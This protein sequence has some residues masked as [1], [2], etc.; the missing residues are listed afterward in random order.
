MTFPCSSGFSNLGQMP[1]SLV[2]RTWESNS[3]LDAPAKYRRACH[4]DAFVPDELARLAI[5]LTGEIAGVLS[6]ADSFVRRLN[7]DEDIALAPLAHLLLRTESIASS[8]IEGLQVGA[9]QLARAEVEGAGNAVSTTAAELIDNIAAMELAIEQA[10]SVRSF[11]RDDIIAIHERLM[12][13][14]PNARVAGV[15]R[16]EQNWIGGNDYNPCAADFVPPPPEAI[17]GLLDDLCTAVNDDLL[18]PL[19]Q[20]ALV[21]AQFETIHPFADGNGRTGRALIHVVLKRRGV[22]PRFVPPIS[23]VFAAARDRYIAGLTAFRANGLNQWIEQ[24]AAATAKA[25][26]LAEGYLAE[27]KHLRDGWRRR[28]AEHTDAPREDAAAW[29]IID[30]LPGHPIITTQLAEQLTGRATSAVYVAIDQLAAAG[31]LS[32]TSDSRRNRSW[33]AVGLLPIIERLEAGEVP[34]RPGAT[35]EASP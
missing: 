21:H 10:A 11:G 25:A 27:I 8:K 5:E 24:F 35:S 23:V 18:P 17:D 16:A 34:A 31:V 1:G 4:Y 12:R 32:P 19:V 3:W 7:A 2:R 22:A 14:A 9:R 15:I 33:E 30:Q 26:S 6:D 29:K 28:L 13:H 20:A